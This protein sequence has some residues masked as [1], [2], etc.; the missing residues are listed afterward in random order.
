MKISAARK[1]ALSLP[2]VSEEP[3]FKYTSFRIGGKIFATVPPDEKSLHVFVGDE[4][5][6]LAVAMF[7]DACEPLFWGKKVV[8]VKVMLSRAVAADV[9]DLLLSAWQRKAPKRLLADHG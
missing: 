5:R 8:G 2:E 3:H 9:E 4:R 7:P 6:E 1:Y